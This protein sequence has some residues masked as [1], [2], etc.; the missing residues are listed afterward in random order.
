VRLFVAAELP[1]G[2]ASGLAAWAR[3]A[4]GDDPALRLVAL[5][6]MH[7]TLA[8]L[9]ERPQEDVGPISEG[10]DAA[11]GDGPWPGEVGVG[12]VLWLAPRRPH[13]LTV[14]LED[15]AGALSSLQE[16]VIAE[17]AGAIGFEPE[18][19]RFRPHVTVARVRHRQRPRSLDLARPPADAPF[20]VEAVTLMRS[21][22][23]GSK[24]ARYEALHRVTALS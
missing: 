14:A 20:A 10:L 3:H 1:P 22:L 11:V 19:R 4:V 15:P 18:R 12:E 23:G 5:E 17:L 24:P 6:S 7:L 13:V 16:R 9:G 21:H 8:F 2:V